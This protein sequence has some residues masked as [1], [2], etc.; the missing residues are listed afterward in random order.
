M[1]TQ[2]NVNLDITWDPP[3]QVSRPL[4]QQLFD[5]FS[6]YNNN[7]VDRNS[8][9]IQNLSINGLE[10]NKNNSRNPNNNN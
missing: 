6:D 5:S 10:N 1:S 3:K 2:N 7:L 9:A 4:S 8:N